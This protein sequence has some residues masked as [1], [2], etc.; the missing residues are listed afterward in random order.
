MSFTEKFSCVEIANVEMTIAICTLYCNAETQLRS[1]SFSFDTRFCVAS[2]AVSRISTMLH[3]ENFYSTEIANEYTDDDW[4]YMPLGLQSIATHRRSCSQL[5]SESTKGFVLLQQLLRV[6]T[7]VEIG[8]PC[9]SGRF[10]GGP[11]GP[12]ATGKM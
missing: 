3:F 7:Q 4:T 12:P 8:N 10:R 6:A 5:V 9:R 2:A 1:T 11:I